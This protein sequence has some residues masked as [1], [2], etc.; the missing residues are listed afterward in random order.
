MCADRSRG[1]WDLLW[2]TSLMA[3]TLTQLT[4][5]FTNSNAGTAPTAAQ[6]A[7]LQGIL[8]Q[9]ATGT[10]TDAQALQAAIDLAAD[11]TT[12]V[13]I[14]TYQ[15]FLG[16]APSEAGLAALNAAYVGSGTQAAANGENRYLAQAISLATENAT[17]KAAF[18][19]KVGSL[20]VADATAL[21]Y[22]EVIGNAA[23]TAAGIN[24]ANAVAFLSSASSIA[25]YT[26]YVTK[27][28]KGL[29]TAA[30]IDLAVKAAL[31]GEIMYAA[32]TFNNGAGVGSYAAATN[33]L[34]KDLADDGKLV[35]NNAAG[36]DLFAKYATPAAAKSLSLTTGIDTLV[37]GDG[38]D[39]I[40]GLFAEG[41]ASD[42]NTLTTFDTIDGGLGVD[43]LNL[44]TST[45]G[46]NA[47]L[48]L[49]A[50]IKNVEIVN[51]Y[52]GG[53]I[54]TVLTDASTY[55]SALQQ[56]WQIG[57]DQDVSNLKAGQTAG[58]RNVN[59]NVNV[60]AADDA[61]SVSVALDNHGTYRYTYVEGQSLSN[62]TISG[63]LAEADEATYLEIQV[64]EDVDTVTLNT[65]VNA[66]ITMYDYN[67]DIVKLDASASAGGIYLSGDSDLATILTGTGDDQVGMYASTVRDVVGTTADETLSATVSTGK[68]D[69]EVYISTSGD[70]KTT[71]TTG[72]GD[73][74]I[75]INT[76]G[77][78]TLTIDAGA[79]DDTVEMYT[80]SGIGYASSSTGTRD[81]VSGGDGVDTL[82]M[83]A[84]V[85]TAASSGTLFE[86]AID[87]FEKISVGYVNSNENGVVD[88]ANLD[89]I[90][91][92]V[93]NG[94]DTAAGIT[95]TA[96][97]T[98]S[99]LKPGQSV[100]V[101]GATYTNSSGVTMAAADVATAFAAA[102][103][104]SGYTENKSGAVITYTSSTVNTNVTDLTV[105]AA[106]GSAPA[107][108]TISTTAEGQALVAGTT[109]SSVVT[110]QGL[111]AGEST[112]VA[113][114][115]VTATAVTETAVVTLNA[116]YADGTSA[117]VNGV[118]VTNGT[119]GP[120]TGA[121]MVTVLLGGTIAGITA[122]GSST[123][124]GYS[125][126]AAGNIVTYTAQSAGTN[127]ADIAASNVASN[128]VTQGRNGNLTATEVAQAFQANNAQGGAA[129]FSGSFSGFTAT[130]I[131]GQSVTFT[132]GTANTNVANISVSSTSG[133]QPTVTTTEGVATIPAVTEN[134]VVTFGALLDGQ[135][136]TVGGR[137]VTASG[138]N[139]TAIEVANAYASN[140]SSGAAVVGGTLTSGWTINNASNA[141]AVVEFVSN[142]AST[143]VTNFSG[144]TSAAATATTP[145]LV[146]NQGSESFGNLTINN[147]AAGGTVEL[148]D[149]NY[150]ALTVN[151]ADTT[152]AADVVNLKLNGG[153][154]LQ[155]PNSGTVVVAGVETINI[156][157]ADQ[158]ALSDPTSAAKPNLVATSAAT[159][160]VSGNHGVN[161]TGSTLSGLTTLN[162]TGVVSTLSSASAAATAAAV[163]FT[164]ASSTS[165]TLS[166][167]TGMGDD[168][169]NLSS[170]TK[171]GATVSTGAGNDVI[172]GTAS[173]SAGDTINA[174]DGNDLVNSSA[175]AD[176]I[177]LGAGKD[178]YK[179][180]AFGHTVLAV[181]DTLT[182]FTA[183]TAA[184]SSTNTAL[185]AQTNEVLRTGDVIDVSV[186]IGQ[187]NAGTN[188][189][190]SA[191]GVV[192]I[193]VQVATNAAD[194][195]TLIQNVAAESTNLTGFALDSSTGKLY[196]DF[197]QDGN[198]DSVI[199]LTGVTTLTN[200]AFI[201]GLAVI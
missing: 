13:S 3:V 95:E 175:G 112:T 184:F 71:V 162:T 101:G 4:S 79:G 45:K 90:S 198:I 48:P 107:L 177:T 36:I 70:G 58:F 143:N 123:V 88:M 115:T 33:N 86:K 166:I 183:N 125:T 135:S 87:G 181:S 85:A 192:G 190:G 28:A 65:S 155:N 174:G 42:V 167:T 37:G 84:T 31:V 180:G 193:K 66:Y 15:Y 32:T 148:R 22:N 17:A 34:L 100:T 89:D 106:P 121:Q 146:V 26:A 197:N 72:E 117:T 187:A 111:I 154:S 141:D 133:T 153:S 158:S 9:N 120:V 109:E 1:V 2:E 186:I 92:V 182:D 144:S 113:G 165:K 179:L 29:V 20:S 136:V 104:I 25:Y 140:V 142:T 73:D 103:D 126:S 149:T 91:Y 69:D 199:T 185:G 170:N 99:D 35:S 147:L 159:V 50:S 21:I 173:A 41:T 161:F 7:G 77:S 81:V 110:F 114:R 195:Q 138:G 129:V 40:T 60:Y 134:G 139:L 151:L 131:S 191:A 44:Y 62:V 200:A 178:V 53:S 164:A 27:N 124:S 61:T 105:S 43:T 10:Y 93:T 132:S 47:S 130:A 157:T 51:L 201:T 80:A 189:F 116:N 39:T 94:G 145:G 160:T 59:S 96:V 171:G 97:V 172:T 68:G 169:I 137:S 11:L 64:G 30:D 128:V 196:M 5:Y 78:H 19:A 118:T 98:F 82:V 38:N 8:N 127:V 49:N 14:Q 67:V 108:A 24:V 57:G 12:S 46:S 122:S 16:F 6:T 168:T 163:T 56:L 194:A 75:T 55:G 152:G 18:A 63:T 102:Y 188:G 119:G 83:S 150:A 23:A 176:V 54:N 52:E 74:Y 156:T 76:R